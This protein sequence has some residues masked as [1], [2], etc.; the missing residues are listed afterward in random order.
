MERYNN[1][2]ILKIMFSDIIKELFHTS[3]AAIISSL[4]RSDGLP[5][6]EVAKE[7]DMSYMGVKQHCINLEKLGFLESVKVPKKDVGRPEKLY[8]LTAKC[9]DLFPTVGSGINIDLLDEVATL[10]GDDAPDNLL[11][12]YFNKREQ[13]VSAITSSEKTLIGKVNALVN[14]LEELG[15]FISITST[16]NITI[17]VYHDPFQR[18]ACTHPIIKELEQELIEKALGC[19]V[20]PASPEGQAIVLYQI[21]G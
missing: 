19:E 17:T 21:E 12:K 3:K 16:D 1:S 8:R 10:Y 18:I 14:Y 15:Y 7:V 4:K 6:S 9:D 13:E 5:V 2:N 20:T 11:R